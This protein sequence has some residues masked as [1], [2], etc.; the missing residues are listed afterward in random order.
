MQQELLR[1]VLPPCAHTLEALFRAAGSLQ[2][3][4]ALLC[5]E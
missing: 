1:N 4:G 2:D 5:A 3:D